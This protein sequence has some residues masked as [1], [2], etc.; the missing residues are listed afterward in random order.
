VVAG[1]CLTKADGIAANLLALK[2]HPDGS[3]LYVTAA[4]INTILLIDTSTLQAVKGGQFSGISPVC[5]AVHPDGSRV[6]VVYN[7][8]NFLAWFESVSG[9]IGSWINVG[10]SPFGYGNFLGYMAETV[11]GK[12]S[13]N[14][15]GVAGIT[16]I[17]TDGE[18]T[19][20]IL[21]D[22]NGNY[23]VALKNGNY[24]I[25]PSGSG[26]SFYPQSLQVNIEQSLSGQDFKI[27]DTAVAPT[28]SLSALPSSIQAG[29]SVTLSW[30]S[31]NAATAMID[32]NIGE[33]P[34]NGSMTVTPTTTTTYTITVSN[35]VLTATASAQVTIAVPLPLVTITALPVAIQPGETST[36]TWTTA[37]TDAVIIDNGIGSVPL[38]GSIPVSPLLTTIYTITA[39]GPGGT[40]SAS[41]SVQV[42]YPAPVVTFTA[43]PESIAPGAEATLSWSS[44]NATALS[45]DN[46]IGSVS[47]SGSITV[48]P[49]STTIY[50]ITANG[51]GGTVTVAAKITVVY[52]VPAVTI[53]A[54]PKSIM[55]GQS[56]ILTWESTNATAAIINQQVVP[57][58]GSLT[59][60]PTQATLYTIN[61][62]G[63]GGTAS[64]NVTITISPLRISIT[65]PA[66]GAV[67]NRP[68]TMVEGT[69][70]AIAGKETGLTV[71]GIPAFIDGNQFVASHVPLVSGANTITA[72]AKDIDGNSA[73][74]STT[75]TADTTQS[76][77]TLTAGSESGVTPLEI[78]LSV[79]GSFPVTSPQLSFSGPGQVEFLSS[80]A[81]GF[82]VRMNIPGVYYFTATAVDGGTGTTYTDTVT[83]QVLDTA[84]LNTLLMN[85][86]S[87]MKTALSVQ[88]ISKAIGFFHKDSRQ[89]Y[90]GIFS[91]LSESLPQIAAEMQDIELIDFLQNSA[92]YR[93]KRSESIQGS[94][95]NISYYIYFC[96]DSDG[97]WR[98]LGF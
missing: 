50:T 61:V 64:A 58:N 15:I 4:D 35:T 81:E 90:Q 56:S 75:I 25:T 6:Y 21:T 71:N 19:K 40:S 45:I 63:P 94:N 82:K 80:S 54:N 59:V 68:D 84:A 73:S 3:K 48:S 11:A 78:L 60:T 55:P 39:T 23:I 8:S 74:I 49:T 41:A 5:L 77:I 69:I 57:V 30:T 38:N 37:N 36:L 9:A 12:V 86:W 76:Y 44:A 10:Q 14:G 62:T 1:L 79:D 93:I 22:S 32:N 51:P 83:V 53:A 34:E 95:Y 31:T 43:V 67:I 66:A 2:I 7:G 26:Y 98:I 97:I 52:P 24:T 92:R 46:G 91:E 88:D 33:V 65:N 72:T 42:I 89:K 70:T 16:M 27:I 20:T 85:K 17:V 96:V 28:V 47:T 87:G 18:N 29:D 13:R